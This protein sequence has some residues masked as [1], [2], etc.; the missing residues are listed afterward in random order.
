M[1]FTNI[2]CGEPGSLHDA[3]VLRRS[4][5]YWES[6]NNKDRIFPNGTFILGDSAYPSLSWLVPPFKNNG[7]LTAQ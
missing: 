6:E 2:Y 7:Q 3:R 1:R 4:N 5:L